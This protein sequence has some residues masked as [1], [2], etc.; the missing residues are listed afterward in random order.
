MGHVTLTMNG[1]SYRLACGEGE[2][3]RL[4]LLAAHVKSKVDAVT[5][6]FGQIGEDRLFLMAALL[7]ADELFEARERA[8]DATPGPVTADGGAD[9]PKPSPSPR[10]TARNG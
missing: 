9:R 5:A 3:T 8:A 1:R 2:E 10:K 7:V 6:Q 4:Q